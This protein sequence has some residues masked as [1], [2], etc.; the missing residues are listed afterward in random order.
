MQRAPSPNNQCSLLLQR[1]PR[2]NYQKWPPKAPPPQHNS[3]D[4]TFY[5]YLDR[6]VTIFRL[7]IPFDWALEVLSTAGEH[8]TEN[9]FRRQDLSWGRQHLRHPPTYRTRLC[10]P[11]IPAAEWCHPP[12]HRVP[13]PPTV[14]H[15]LLQLWYLLPVGLRVAGNAHRWIRRSALSRPPFAVP[16]TVSLGACRLLARTSWGWTQIV[17][18]VH[19]APPGSF[20]VS[21]VP[22]WA[23]EVVAVPWSV[24]CI[25]IGDG[26]SRVP[27]RLEYLVLS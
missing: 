23:H 7:I 22:F 24:F 12:L 25:A 18:S 1:P 10:R 19:L 15:G 16:S 27:G 3:V 17:R 26:R 8:V 14:E 11:R 13:D 21:V 4:S 9:T 5:R 6:M 20:F 2:P